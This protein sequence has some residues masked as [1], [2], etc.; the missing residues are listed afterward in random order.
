MGMEMQTI[1]LI[2]NQNYQ[3]NLFKHHLEIISY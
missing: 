2:L 1:H 3:Q